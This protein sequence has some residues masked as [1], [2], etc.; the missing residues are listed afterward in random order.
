MGS[1]CRNVFGFKFSYFLPKTNLRSELKMFSMLK[2]ASKLFRPVY[3]SLGN[4][5]EEKPMSGAIEGKGVR[6]SSKV[7]G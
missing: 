2:C 1:N 3:F 5:S 4:A 7:F 6:S